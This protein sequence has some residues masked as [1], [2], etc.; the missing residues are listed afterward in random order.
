MLIGIIWNK[1]NKRTML[2]PE[3]VK[4]LLEANY[5]AARHKLYKRA[6]LSLEAVKNLLEAN[7]CTD[8]NNSSWLELNLKKLLY[9]N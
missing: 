5:C 8:R 7:C 1:L 6:M 2:S 4:K 3:A 9:L